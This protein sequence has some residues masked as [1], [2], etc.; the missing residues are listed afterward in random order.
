MF[1]LSVLTG[2]MK[3]NATTKMATPIEEKFDQNLKVSFPPICV[4]LLKY[5]SNT[6]RP[7][8]IADAHRDG[9]DQRWQKQTRA[10]PVASFD[11]NDHHSETGHIHSGSDANQHQ[12][13][14]N[15]V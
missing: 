9:D 1:F 12:S 15:R 6:Q 5:H 2:N 14:T 8:Q 11:G 10:G 13:S 7:I 4:A 3:I